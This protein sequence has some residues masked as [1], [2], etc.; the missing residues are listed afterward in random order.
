[1]AEDKIYAFQVDRK[2]TKTDI[3]KAIEKSFQVKVKSVRT[4]VCRGRSRRTRRG[5]GRVPYWKKAFVKIDKSDTIS[6]FEGV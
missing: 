5:Q 3:K 6:L 4:S 1:M 2:A